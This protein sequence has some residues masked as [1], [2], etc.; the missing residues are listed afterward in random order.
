M[1]G[2]SFAPSK[3]KKGEN[4]ME[5]R[6]RSL[7]FDIAINNVVCACTYKHLAASPLDMDNLHFNAL[8]GN[9]AL[10]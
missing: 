4:K 6:V 7:G 2:S 1:R 8:Q 10:G 9:L 5:Y 3:Q